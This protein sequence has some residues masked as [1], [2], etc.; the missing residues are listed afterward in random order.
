MAG[1]ACSSAEWPVCS[2]A[3]ATRRLLPRMQAGKTVAAGAVFRALPV[4]WS[5]VSVQ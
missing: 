5:R 2:A 4:P 3:C 1:Q